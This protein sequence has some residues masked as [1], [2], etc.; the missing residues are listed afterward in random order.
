MKIN[1]EFN[2]E[3]FWDR[4]DEAIEDLPEG[5]KMAFCVIT[6]IIATIAILAGL[7]TIVFLIG[8]TYGLILTPLLYFVWILI[9]NIV[10]NYQ[11][12]KEE[13]KE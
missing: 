9:R 11:K 12:I 8:E 6:F 13:E 4:L 3:K 1:L 5:Q 2:F 10:K 7:F